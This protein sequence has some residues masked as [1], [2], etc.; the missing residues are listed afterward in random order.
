MFKRGHAEA[1]RKLS[2]GLNE[3]IL[4]IKYPFADEVS[5][6]ARSRHVAL[7]G[8]ILGAKSRGKIQRKYPGATSAGGTRTR[9]MLP[10]VVGW[11][12]FNYKGERTKQQQASLYN[13]HHLEA[14]ST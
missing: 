12:K 11:A 6:R 7:L 8:A 13:D 2:V 14:L 3:W 10:R 1:I 9:A 4:S 5:A